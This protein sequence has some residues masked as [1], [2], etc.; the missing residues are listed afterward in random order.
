MTGKQKALEYNK[1]FIDALSKAWNGESLSDVYKKNEILERKNQE[2]ER[3]SQE[4]ERKSQET[5][6][7]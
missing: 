7:E 6:R 5:E 3:K 2:I 1:G 4:I